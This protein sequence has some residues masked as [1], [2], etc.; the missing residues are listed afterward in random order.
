MTVDPDQR[1]R[2]EWHQLLPGEDALW[3]AVGEDLIARHSGPQ[4]AYHGWAH[5]LAVVEILRLLSTDADREPSMAQMIAAFFHDAVYDATATGGA[6][7]E[8][9]ARLAEQLLAPFV[10]SAQLRAESVSDAAAMIRATAGHQLIDVD[11]ADVFLDADLAILGADPATYH[12][13]TNAIRGEYAHLDDQTFRTGRAAILQ[14][15]LDRD[16]LYFTAAGRARFEV[17]ARV[18]LAA[19]IAELS[20]GV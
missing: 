1:F 6:N 2:R 10:E 3:I 11:G 13:Y 15:F 4:R 19:E 14:T 8:A 7:E 17:Q 18:N 9:S 12:W 16:A 5:I 20:A